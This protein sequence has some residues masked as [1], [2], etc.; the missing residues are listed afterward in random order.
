[1]PKINIEEAIKKIKKPFEPLHLVD[2]GD[3]NVYLVE[4]KGE[5]K[6][7]KHPYDELFYVVRGEVEIELDQN[8]EKLKAGEGLLVKK[9]EFHKSKSKKSSVVMMFEKAGL[10]MLF[11]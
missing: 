11:K 1:M 5:Y 2:V 10:N 9:G 3:Y 4:L 6:R 8:T 7:H